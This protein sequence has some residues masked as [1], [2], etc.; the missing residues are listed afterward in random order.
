MGAVS[1]IANTPKPAKPKARSAADIEAEI[2]ATRSR[3]VD[4]IDTLQEQVKPQNIAKRG[5]NKVKGFYIKEDGGV[6]VERVAATGAAVVGLVLLRRGL[7]A[8]SNRRAVES[9]PDV[10]WVPVPKGSIP[11]PLHEIARR[12]IGG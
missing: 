3:L 10:M 1:E 6:R 2:E 8:M 4:T 5:I 12:A 7:R 11:A 9:M